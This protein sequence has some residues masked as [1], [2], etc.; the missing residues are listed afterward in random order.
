MGKTFPC[1]TISS[2]PRKWNNRGK[3]SYVF[4]KTYLAHLQF[5]WSQGLWQVEDVSRKTWGWAVKIN[6]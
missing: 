4:V 6:D 5:L 3:D 1:R 2:Q